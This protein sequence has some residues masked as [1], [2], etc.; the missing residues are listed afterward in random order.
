MRRILI[1]CILI[2]ISSAQS[3]QAV[4]PAQQVQVGLTFTFASAAQRDAAL[5]DIAKIY[6]LDIYSDTVYDGQ[7]NV[8]VLG[9]TIQQNKVI[10][11]VRDHVAKQLKQAIVDYRAGKEG[12][13]AAAA[14]RASENAALNP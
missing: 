7:G 12:R 9:T 5:L 2:I 4:I 14:K 6:L 13:D 11:A 3:G 1:L 8:I 10:P